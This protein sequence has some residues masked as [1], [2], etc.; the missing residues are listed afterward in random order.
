MQLQFFLTSVFE[1]YLDEI[2]VP[3]FTN[4]VIPTPH[5]RIVKNSVNHRTPFDGF[6]TYFI[7]KKNPTSL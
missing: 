4:G 2:V 5:A 3:L 7:Y 6:T 1:N